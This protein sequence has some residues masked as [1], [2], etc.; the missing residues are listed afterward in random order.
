MN[1][2]Y[3]LLILHK[4]KLIIGI[5]IGYFSTINKTIEKQSNVMLI[6]TYPGFPDFYYILGA[7]LGSLLYGD[8]SVMLFLL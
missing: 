8:V 3:K 1:F 4:R 5:T 2:I 7:N 6:N